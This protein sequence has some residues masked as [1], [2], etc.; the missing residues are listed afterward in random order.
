MVLCDTWVQVLPTL[1][2]S[3]LSLWLASVQLVSTC[4]CETFKK[5]DGTLGTTQSDAAVV[6]SRRAFS[7][8]AR[9][10]HGYVALS[11]A[12]ARSHSTVQ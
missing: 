8:Q 4:L 3:F 5:D 6:M 2:V 1:S 7:M 11:D 10:P 9:R 12:T